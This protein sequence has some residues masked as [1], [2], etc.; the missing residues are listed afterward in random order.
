MFIVI[1]KLTPK[2]KGMG[3]KNATPSTIVDNKNVSLTLQK[4]NKSF[5][6]IKIKT[7]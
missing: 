6:A 7:Q 5:K 3:R 2:G 1:S 4:S